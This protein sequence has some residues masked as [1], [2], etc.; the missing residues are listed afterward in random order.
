MQWPVACSA[1]K[2]SMTLC[3]KLGIKLILT[4]TA[5][6]GSSLFA[7]L[8]A[9]TTSGGFVG[10]ITDPAGSVVPGAT[11]QLQDEATSIT[12]S[13]QTSESGEYTFSYVQPG[14]YTIRVT[15]QGFQEIVVNHINLDIQQAARKDFSLKVG[16]A[17][18]TVTV[19]SDTTPLIQTDS[20]YV[21]NVVDGKQIQQSPLNGRENAYSLL[22]LAPGVQRPNSNALISGSSFKGGIN[23]TIDGIS[24]NDIVG[25]RISDQVPSLEAMAQFNTIGVNAPA[26]Y[27]N[28]GAQVIIATKS[29]TNAFHG[30]LFEF[31]RNRYF[32]ARNF[33]LTPGSKIPGFNRN[34]YGGSVGGP[35]LKN[36]LFFFFT[37]ENIHSLTTTTRQYS[38]PTP[39][40]LNG[41]FSQYTSLS[42]RPTILYNPLTKLP[43]LNNKLPAGSISARSRQFLKYYSTPNTTTATGLGNNFTYSSPTLELDPRYSIRSDYQISKADHVMFRYYSNRRVPSPYDTGGTDKFGNYQYLGNI[44]NQ[45]SS[46]YTRVFSDSIVNEL[47]F[48]VN[49]RADPRVSQNNDVNAAELIPGLPPT[50][51]G[52]GILPTVNVMGIQQIFDTGSSNSHQHTVQLNDNLSI[53]RGHHN[54]KVGGQFLAEAETQTTYNAGSFSFDGRYTGQYALTGQSSNE[55]NAFADFLLGY[56]SG[57]A[58]A[59]NSDTVTALA[60]TYAFY[61]S[62][63]WNATPKLTFNLGLRYDKLFPFQVT[64][65]GLAIFD[66]QLGKLVTIFGTP[67][68]VLEAAYPTIAGS[69]I[70]YRP[71]NWLHMQNL[72]FGPRLGFAFRPFDSQSF[73]IRGGYGIYYN[74][75]P[76]NDLVNSLNNQLPFILSTSY[77]A[78]SSTQPSLTFDNPFP[79]TG[80]TAGNPN[81]AGVQRDIKTPY[82]QQ[83]N[84]TIEDEAWKRIALRASY[85]GNL[86]THLHT[87]Y[88]LNDVI[89]QPLGGAGQ[90]AT[91]QA[92]RPFQP[93]ANITYYLYGESSNTNQLQLAA[94]RRFSQ[95]SFDLEYQYT[96]A[97]GIDGPNEEVVTNKLDIRRDYGNLDY[98]ARHALALNYSYTLPV[99]QGQWL[100]PHTGNFLNRIIGGWILTGIWKAQTG[101]PFSVG[102]T[103]TLNGF[104]SG[105]ANYLGTA[106]YP[107]KQSYMNWFNASAFAIPANYT[108]GNSQRNMLFGPGFSQWDAGVLKDIKISD[109]V[110]FQFRAEAFD[111]LNRTNFGGPA[112]NISVPTTIGRSTSTGADNRELQF[113]GRLSF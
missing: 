38:M 68:P 15:I 7:T 28:G 27:G 9:Q 54:L 73:V 13:V 12:S 65:G 63:T 37:Y 94:R 25:A 106:K 87:P 60:K 49:K 99:G 78:T 113:G 1:A 23:Q 64:Q 92:A 83:F 111:V 76:L 55:V 70:G 26:E 97:L 22:G 81:A 31:N 88:P 11:V 102:F 34:E 21:G 52:F 18:A 71:D 89:P 105:R 2:R 36:K 17:L 69:T 53:T 6:L 33:F 41:D 56:M 101:S 62:D 104:P 80:A 3:K 96:K 66:P 45:F 51:K 10:R 40:F 82:N 112:A 42:G 4:G 35:I 84:L 100:L 61:I 43:F 50:P 47:V 108:F 95:L 75:L 57:S 77:T 79:T 32:Q 29:G 24:N 30:S 93:F 20:S 74:N 109:R 16:D 90:P 8:A 72:N 91:V 67:D 59:N 14:T 85:I 98:Y 19:L 39:A 5:V 44:I 58:T 86:G 107:G 48:G 46:S 110:N 103:S